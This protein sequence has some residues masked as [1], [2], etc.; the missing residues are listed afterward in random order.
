VR[1]IPLEGPMAIDIAR[2]KFISRLGGMTVALPLAARGQQPTMPVIGFLSS[3]SPG[4]FAHLVAAFRQAL[5][6]TGYDEGRNVAFEYRWAESQYD[7]L[8]GMAADLV[9]RQVAVIA[10]F[11]PSAAQAAKAATPII[12]IV[13]TS[14]AD[15]VD[16][17]LVT[18]LSRP[19]GNVTGVYL[20]FTG[21][22]AKKL[23]LLREVI[24]QVGVIAALLNPNN[25]DAES[26]SRELQAAART[27][28]EQMQTFNAISEI[29][30]DAAFVMI[31]QLRAGA[32]LIGSD[33]LFVDCRDQIVTLSARH[34]IA[35]VYETR[36]SVVAGGLMSYGTS[37]TDGYRQVGIYTGR[38]LKGDKP[39]D[40]P[41]VQSTKFEFV[42]N[43]KTAKALGLTIPSGVLAIA[44]EVIE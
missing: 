15:P 37:L 16:V 28:G 29:E 6:E 44:D 33:P 13:F 24:P 39:S 25:P 34:A 2:R 4:P 21:L 18:S 35:T 10:A 32:L 22:E 26:Q 5:S 9:R 19:G 7:R 8:P 41:V 42:I 12:P 23:G 1:V 14:G 17:G 30:I 43:L 38:V 20:F 40:L 36:E 27:L 3:G 31:A 11:G